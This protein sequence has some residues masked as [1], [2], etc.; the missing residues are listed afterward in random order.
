MTDAVAGAESLLPDWFQPLFLA[1]ALGG[2][3]PPS[4][5][6]SPGAPSPRTPP[7]RDDFPR[8]ATGASRGPTAP[9]HPYH[10]WSSLTWPPPRTTPTLVLRNARIHTVDPALPEAGAVAVT[11]GRIAWLG[12]DDD[13]TAWTGPRTRVIDAAGKL[14]LPGFIDAHNHAGWAPTTPAIST[15]R[16][17][18]CPRSS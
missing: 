5:G 4:T 3:V 1:L 18:R 2:S 11:D 15:R 17:A 8:G 12:P 16:P 10:H 6:P 14:V 13:A 7:C 9:N